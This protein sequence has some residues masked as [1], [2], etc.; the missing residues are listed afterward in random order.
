[1]VHVFKPSHRDRLCRS[2]QVYWEGE[3]GYKV[4]FVKAAPDYCVYE[5]QHGPDHDSSRKRKRRLKNNSEG[6]ASFAVTK[7][8]GCPAR[9]VLEEHIRVVPNTNEFFRPVSIY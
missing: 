5:C 1:M 7:K 4:P 6:R 8:V 3:S 2:L 9:I